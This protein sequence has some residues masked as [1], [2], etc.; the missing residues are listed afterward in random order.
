[1]DEN[2]Y[3]QTQLTD[4][5]GT[6]RTKF[7]STLEKHIVYKVKECNRKD[8]PDFASLIKEWYTFAIFQLDTLSI[9]HY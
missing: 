2:T 3:Q 7:S 1:M 6:I 8:K 4:Y 9:W 5:L